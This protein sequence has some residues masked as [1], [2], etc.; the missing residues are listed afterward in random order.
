MKVS[1][2]FRLLVVSFRIQNNSKGW[3]KSYKEKGEKGIVLCI[4]SE[5]TFLLCSWRY[6]SNSWIWSLVH[7]RSTNNLLPSLVYLLMY[8]V[9]ANVLCRDLDCLILEW[10]F[11]LL[12]AW[13]KPLPTVSAKGHKTG[14]GQQEDLYDWG[15]R[16]IDSP[17][18]F[19]S[20]RWM[21]PEQPEQDILTLN[22]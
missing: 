3:T 9:I 4:L 16:R 13:I 20:T 7:Y 17:S 8:S 21:A 1:G 15:E 19:W 10:D 22:S 12:N 11:D 18:I 2:N 5:V 6:C 14:L